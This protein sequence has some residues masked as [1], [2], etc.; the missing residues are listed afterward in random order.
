MSSVPLPPPRDA[1]NHKSPVFLSRRATGK[2]PS[3]YSNGCLSNTFTLHTLLHFAASRKINERT[4]A[5]RKTKKNTM[6]LEK[7]AKTLAVKLT[8]RCITRD[9][10]FKTN[11]D[12]RIFKI[13]FLNFFFFL[14]FKIQKVPQHS[15]P[16]IPIKTITYNIFLPRTDGP[17]FGGW[18]RGRQE[19]ARLFPRGPSKITLARS[20]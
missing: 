1:I 9:T 20:V 17:L 11:R 7:L 16:L 12:Y 4:P 13:I 19:P 10:F 5:E 2:F 8:R 14:H 3:E 6:H 15:H 18:G